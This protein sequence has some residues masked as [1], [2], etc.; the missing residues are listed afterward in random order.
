MCAFVP[1][2][3][4]IRKRPVVAATASVKSQMREGDLHPRSIN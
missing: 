1:Y 2:G 4:A 3:A